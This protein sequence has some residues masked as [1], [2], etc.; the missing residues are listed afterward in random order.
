[1]KL[2][3]AIT[4]PYV[5]KV[6]VVIGEPLLPNVPVGGR[7][8][9]AALAE[10]SAMLHAELQ[11]LFDRAMVGVGWSYP[12]VVADGDATASDQ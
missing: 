6:R 7:V 10:Q 3:G 9:R 1:M 11:R 5:R 4:S 12:P 2:I 8:P